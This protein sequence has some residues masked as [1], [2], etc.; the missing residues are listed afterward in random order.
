MSNIVVAKW[1]TLKTDMNLATIGFL[2]RM[3]LQSAGRPPRHGLAPRKMFSKLLL[4]F[5]VDK[6]KQLFVG[7]EMHQYNFRAWFVANLINKFCIQ[8][9]KLSKGEDATSIQVYPLPLCTANL[10][11]S[12]LTPQPIR[13]TCLDAM[14]I[15]FYQ[16]KLRLASTDNAYALHRDII[17]RKLRTF[18]TLKSRY[19]NWTNLRYRQPCDPTLLRKKEEY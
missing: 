14:A 10:D 18:T 4:L 1:P 2:G 15:A 11:P 19:N 13:V 17:T 9:L 3:M 5:H 16:D 6:I 8:M 7:K 12:M